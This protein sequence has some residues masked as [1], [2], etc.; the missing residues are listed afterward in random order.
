MLS[1]GYIYGLLYT[2]FAK[3]ISSLLIIERH[4]FFCRLLARRVL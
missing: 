2:W 4:L 1:A 3:T